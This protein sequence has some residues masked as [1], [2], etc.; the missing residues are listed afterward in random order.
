M[1]SDDTSIEG[2]LKSYIESVKDT[3][4][5]L[6]LDEL[7]GKHL[8]NDLAMDSLDIINMLFRIEETEGV[9][10]SEADMESHSLFEFS[11]LAAHLRQKRGS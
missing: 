4:L 2:R 9:D 5:D 6:E 7:A 1:T 8:I 3:P 11:R 10:I